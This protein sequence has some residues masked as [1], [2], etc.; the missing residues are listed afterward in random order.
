MAHDSYSKK[1]NYSGYDKNNKERQKDDFYATPPCE[2]LNILQQLKIN[3]DGCNILDTCMGQGHLLL[4]VQEYLKR[5]NQKAQLYGTDL[6][7]RELINGV[8]GNFKFG[9]EYDIFAKNYLTKLRKLN[10]Y[11]DYIIINPPFKHMG[12]FVENALTIAQ[13]GV[14]IFGRIQFLEGVQRF[15]NLHQIM[16]P[17]DIYGYIERVSCFKDGQQKVGGVQMHAWFYY[18]M[19]EDYPTTYHF[20]HKYRKEE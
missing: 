10:G 11:Y 9:E 14:I 18:D 20:L 15:K 16:P 3:F 6:V 5:N 17:N 19:N 2:V 13:K 8:Q 12:A 4:G 1:G 7:E